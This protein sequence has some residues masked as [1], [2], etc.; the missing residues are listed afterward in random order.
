MQPPTVFDQD[1]LPT[2]WRWVMHA[3]YLGSRF[4]QLRLYMHLV[5]PCRAAD[6]FRVALRKGWECCSMVRRLWGSLAFD[7]VWSRTSQDGPLL[8]FKRLL[9]EQGLEES[10]LAAGPEWLK[11]HSAHTVLDE[12]L[13]RG[14]TLHGSAKGGRA[15]EML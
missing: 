11:K 14:A 5:L 2:L 3:T 9:Q 10:F 13:E 7:E 6:P 1:F 15:S 4:G 12:A 8:S